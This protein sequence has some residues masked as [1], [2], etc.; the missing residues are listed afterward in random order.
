METTSVR[1]VER[2]VEILEVIKS[3]GGET[4]ISTIS[5]ETGLSKSTV[6]RILNALRTKGMVVKDDVTDHYSLGQKI[7]ELA[8]SASM[9]WD[10]ISLAMPYLE[11]LRDSLGE[12]AALAL[13]I[14]K[15]YSFI[16]QAMCR[17]EYRVNPVLGERYC[18]H[19]AGTGKAILAFIPE[20][21]ILEMLALIP[22]KQATSRTITD[23]QKMKEQISEIRNQGFA[24]SFS[25]RIEG[26]ASI[27]APIRDGAGNAQAA[28]SLIGPEIRFR[29]LDLNE[30][31]KAVVE[32]GKQIEM[33]YR[34]AGIKLE[35]GF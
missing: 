32:A 15:D 10:I 5:R 24:F 3:K 2:A 27:S 35:K 7:I 18:L 23:P 29:K 13:R 14:D 9:Q 30:A 1:S 28:V 20:E 31:G 12:T 4:G 19:W 16:A 34:G 17:H 21:E 8:F 33:V 6:F 22:A 25:E 26:G 11:K